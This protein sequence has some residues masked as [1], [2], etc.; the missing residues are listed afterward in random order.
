MLFT[1]YYGMAW[2]VRAVPK[3]WFCVNLPNL[4]GRFGDFAHFSMLGSGEN[5]R[6]SIRHNRCRV[7][8]KVVSFE[9]TETERW[10]K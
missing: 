7:F 9:T 3:K 6:N 5:A 10:P 1:A 8:Q 2:I 4:D